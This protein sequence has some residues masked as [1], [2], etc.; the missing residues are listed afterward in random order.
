MNP[1][2]SA[3]G[4][5]VIALTGLGGRGGGRGGT[6]RGT[7]SNGANQRPSL[8]DLPPHMKAMFEAPPPII[9]KG[10][11]IMPEEIKKK[12][13]KIITT[14]N[15]KPF[16]ST[17]TGIS[18][19]IHNMETTPAP[20]RI[21]QALPK[22][23]QEKRKIKK[24]QKNKEL[25]ELNYSKW[26]V[27]SQYGVTENAYH[28]LFIGNLSYDTSDKKLKR[29]FESVGKVK[30]VILVNDK[31]GKP[32]GYGFIEF[33]LE[34]D[35]TNAYKKMHGIR[36]DGRRIIVDVERGRTVRNWKPMRFGGGLGG[37]KE[38]KSKKVLM[39]ESKKLREEE[40][41]LRKANI[42]GPGRVSSSGSSGDRDR[43]RGGDRRG[44][45]RGSSGGDRY[46]P[47]A[48][49]YNDRGNDGRVSD[50][51]RRDDRY[52]SNNNN[53]G[54]GGGYKRQ[55][56]RS[57]DRD[58]RSGG[59]DRYGGGDNRYGGG[60]DNRRRDDSRERRY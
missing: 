21:C 1:A 29:E 35:M 5:S 54:G 52:S 31:E 2:Y 12:I 51:D 60:N 19:F 30:N 55:R 56:S 11:V 10:P 32:R 58:D 24:I 8:L 3:I 25:I 7:M 40:D 42:Y 22:E 15:N 59:G 26:D 17:Y 6:P 13:D 9:A 27:H 16:F 34:D 23:K 57:R 20:K 4:A 45:S 44:D 18:E 53:D 33:E 39:E 37:R 14:N 38:K 46:V 50:R 49:T 36:I 47:I 28:T 43:D 48:R 41:K